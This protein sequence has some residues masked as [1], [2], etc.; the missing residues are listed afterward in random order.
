[1]IKQALKRQLNYL[2][3]D[4]NNL[5]LLL[6]ISDT[7][8]Q[9]HDLASA[10]THLQH[11]LSIVED[12]D[13]LMKATL[14]HHL[15]QTDAAITLL[16]QSEACYAS[17]AEYWGFL[18]LLYLDNQPEKAK[19]AS[20]NALRLNPKQDEAQ[21]V[22]CLLK[23][24]RFEASVADIEA[25]L[26]THPRE[27]RL[28]FSLGIT[29][30]RLMDCI[31]AKTAFL[32][33]AEIW[34]EFYDNYIAL[35][36]C[37]I[38]QNHLDDAENTYQKAIAL[39]PTLADGFAGMALVYALRQQTTLAKEWLKKAEEMEP[40]CFLAG[41]TRLML[42]SPHEKDTILKRFNSTFPEV[43]MHTSKIGGTFH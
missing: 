14:L 12:T 4:P 6:T 5:P 39:D 20:S 41:V 10:E 22:E 7:Y 3:Q 36:W 31:A 32:K 25:L 28:W 38:L 27:C 8:R 19:K 43:I 23:V 26:K 21:W 37:T 40:D 15:Q 42:C 30:L 35:G 33:T 1:M 9:L 16:E 17:N 2:Q 24:A 18:A 29:Q 34:P 11:A 13:I